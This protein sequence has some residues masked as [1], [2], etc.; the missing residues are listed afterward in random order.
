MHSRLT[1]FD[2]S[3]FIFPFNLILFTS[4]CLY[5]S[6]AGCFEAFRDILLLNILL[7]CN[8]NIANDHERL[9]CFAPGFQAVILK[10]VNKY[11]FLERFVLKIK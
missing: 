11:E 8:N 2:R 5:Q 6:L 7:I 9:Y 3:G 1:L 4:G 10:N